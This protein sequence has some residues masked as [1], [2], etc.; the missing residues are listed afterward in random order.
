LADKVEAPNAQAVFGMVD[1]ATAGILADLAPGEASANTHVAAMLTSNVE[2]LHAYEEGISLLDRVLMADA[3]K[4]FQRA[5]ELD[6]QFAMAW[7]RWASLLQ[8]Q[9][10]DL[11]AARRACAKASALAKQLPIPRIQKLLIKILQLS[12][13]GRSEESL[14]ALETAVHEFPRE[15]EPRIVLGAQLGGTSRNQEAV[16]ALQEVVR[17]DPKS[18]PGYVLLTYNYSYASDL[19]RA[20]AALDQYTTLVPL[21]DPNPIDTRGDVFSLFGKFDE[22][23]QQYNKNAQL[24]PG[25]SDSKVPLVYLMQGKYALADTSAS[26]LYA[27]GDPS[28]KAMIAGILGD[29]EVGRGN[30]DRAAA[31]YEESARLFAARPDSSRGPLRKAAQVYFEQGRPDTALALGKRFTSPDSAGI[32]AAAYLVMKN[33]AAAEKELDSLRAQETPR[34][35]DFGAAGAVLIYRLYANTWAGQWQEALAEFPKLSLQN[36]HATAWIAGRACAETGD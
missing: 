13:D 32:R 34:L 4:A 7:Y 29:I 9:L 28:D 24:N 10:H 33:Q 25:F 6:P 8:V 16:E 36:Q 18:A 30:L 21:N 26:N 20:L 15:T 27:H 23:L 1:Q 11:A 22:A 14:E 35:G 19:P 2:A 17:L 31:R 5:T 3:A 12:L